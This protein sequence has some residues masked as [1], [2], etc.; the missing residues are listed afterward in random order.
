LAIKKLKCFNYVCEYNS[1]MTY[2]QSYFRII[3]AIWAAGLVLAACGSANTA[4]KTKAVTAKYGWDNKVKGANGI[5][6][7][8][9]P[10][11]GVATPSIT[12]LA[13]K[14]Y[15]FYKQVINPADWVY[16]STFHRHIFVGPY[17]KGVAEARVMDS[18]IYAMTWKEQLT[19]NASLQPASA[20]PGIVN[21]FNYHVQGLPIILQSVTAYSNALAKLANELHTTFSASVPSEATI[22]ESPVGRLTAKQM[23]N[24][25]G[26]PQYT[27]IGICVP[28]AFEIYDARHQP[29]LTGVY[30]APIADYF[31]DYGN[32][33]VLQSSSNS[34]SF[35]NGAGFNPTSSCASMP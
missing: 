13:S 5:P 34:N 12:K 29:V 24:T 26:Q 7:L 25:P 28:H 30:S 23:G 33:K 27:T 32:T 20:W 18:K 31:A 19:L 8:K 6:E 11:A 14:D 4:S 3:G 15:A 17:T 21:G 10:Y 22:I 35:T 2:K 16:S 1:I 9:L